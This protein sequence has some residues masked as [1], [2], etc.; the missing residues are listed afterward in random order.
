MT[1][2]SESS[3]K[4][5][6]LQ[7]GMLFDSLSNPQSGVNIEQMLCN[8][9]ENLQASAFVQAWQQVVERHPILRTSFCWSGLGAP[10]QR[11][12][13]HVELPSVE[14][15]WRN[16]SEGDRK[17]QLQDY[18]LSDRQRGFDLTQAP[19]MR[20][21]L[22]RM[23]D[24]EYALIWTFHHIL[25][26][27]ASIAILLQEVF[28]IYEASR[29]GQS[30]ELNPPHPYEDYIEWLQQQDLSKAEAFWKRS[31]SGF[32][33]PTPLVV[34]RSTSGG[35]IGHGEVAIR[36]SQT[37]T[38]TLKSL[39]QDR[40]LA[41][42]TLL[43]GAW[44]LLLSH[45]SDSEDV[46]FGA[47]RDCGRS[48]LQGGESRVGLFINTLPIRVIVPPELP[49][50]TWL[51]QLQAQRMSLQECDRTP[52]TKAQEW[53]DIPHGTPLFES[54][55]VF[56]SDAI[57]SALQALGGNW[58]NRE[59]QLL[60]QTSFPLT[61][62]GYAGSE[63]LLKIAYDR[64][65]FDSDT[66]NRM[67]GHLMTLLEGIAANPHQQLAQLPLL[68]V[69]E[70]QQLWQWNETQA[71]YPQEKCV[72][73]LFETQVER[74][75]DAIAALLPATVPTVTSQAQQQ[76]L[77][78]RELN[79]RANQLAHHLQQLGVGS[80]VLVAIC[81][82]RSLDV[83]I[84]V[85]GILKA[86][87]AYVPVD[88]AYPSERIAFMLA[89]TQAPVI[90]TQ[91]HLVESLPE[92]QARVVCLDA[93]WETISCNSTASPTSSVRP[94][95]LTYTIYTSGS[96]GRPKGVALQHRSLVNLI[97]WQLQNSTLKSEA[98]TLQFASLSFDV[99]F[100]EMF[101]TW[102]AG[103]TLVFIS[104]E[105]RRDALSL[106][107][108]I[109]NE[110]IQRLFLPF[111]AL[112]H[113]AEAADTYE[114]V[115]KAL[116]EVVTAGEQLQVNRYI[117]SFFEQLEDCS[118]HNQ[119][120][121]SE[122]HVVTAYT[123]TGS[124]SQWSALPPI[125]R[126]IANTQIYLLDRHLQPVPVGVP[127]EL[128][129]GGVGVARGYLNR[130]EL[131]QEKF[132]PNPFNKLKE[133]D[134]LYKSGD[135]ARYLP[136]G[137]IE[138]IGRI[139]NQ[140]KIRG[141]RIELGEIETALG[142][143]PA[144]KQAV[145]LVRE[146]EP[147]DKRLVA[148]IVANPEQELVTTE[149]RCYLL[150]MLPDYMIPAIFMTVEAMP[151]TPSGKIDRRALPAPDS[152]RHQSS[153]SYVAPQSEL[154]YCLASIWS[155][156]L[157]LDKVGIHDNFFELGGN[158]LLTLQIAAQ[159]RQK[160][161]IDLPIVKLFQHPTIAQLANYLSQ[162]GGTRPSNDKFQNRVERQK[163]AFERR[164][165]S[166]GDDKALDGVAIIGMV[167]RF[168][169]AATV[170]ELWQNLCNGV[171]STTF[172]TDEEL[173]SSIDIN[174]RT[175]PNYV[176]AR[177]TI[178]DADRFDAAFFGINPRE[179][180]VMD[181]Q[182]RVFLEMAWTALE[183]A[184]YEPDSY[185]GAVGVYAGMGNNTYYPNN[186]H[187]R[188][189]VIS[190]VGEFQVM[191][192][193]EKDY[194]AT[195][196]SY[197]LNLKGPSV[198]VHTACSTSL[199]A[200][201]QAFHSLM[202]N[203]CDL[204]L[205]GGISITVPQNSG[206]SYQEGGMFSSDGRC[207]P[208]DAKAQGTL[209][210]NGVGVVVL[211]RLNDALQDG[212]RVYAVIRGV[213][214]N[215]DGSGKM[216]FAAPSVDGQAEAIAMAHADA[217]VHPDTIS[218]VEAHGT[219]TPLG[220]PIEIAAL[221]QAF[222]TQ[223]QAK[224]F[225]AIGSLKSNFGH[226]VAAAG[227]TGLIKTALALK[228][229]QL[230]PTL[231][232]EQPNPAI[233]FANS[234]FYVNAKLSEWKTSHTPRRAG[235]SSFGVGGTNAHVVLEEAPI[236]EP[237]SPSR[238][239]Q[240][241]LLSAKT[242]SA[243]DAATT[244]LRVHL[245]ERPDINLADVAYTLQ[246]GRKQ[247]N[248]RRFAVCTD[249][250]EATQVLE[251]LPP[252]QVATR[253]ADSRNPAVIFM[254]PGQG[255]QY[256]NMGLNLYEREPV[257][258]EAVDRCADILQPLLDRDL[259]KVLYPGDDE[260]AAAESLRQTFVTQ[261][262][263]FTIEYALAMLWRSWGVH[264]QGAIGHSI[265]EFVAA[266]LAGVFSLENAL[267]LVATRGRLMQEL[268]G[269][270]MLSV[271]LPAAEVERRLSPELTIAAVNAPELCVVS[272]PTDAIATLQ[273]QLERESV[274]CKHLHTSHA[275]HSPMV[276]SIIEPFAEQVRKVQLSPPSIPFVSTVTATWI[277]SEQATDPMYWARHLRATVRFADGVQELWQEPN[278]VLLEVGPRTTTATLA[279]K[280]AKDLKK[281]V[282]ISSLNDTAANE[283]ECSA[284]LNAVGQLWLCGVAIDWHS[285]YK[286][287]NRYRVPLPTYPFERKRFWV[288][289]IDHKTG[290]QTQEENSPS[291]IS[292]PQSPVPNSQVP[293]SI[294]QLP[295][296]TKQE[297]RQD[298]LI[299]L[300]KNV[301]EETSGEELSS[302]DEA[303]TFLEMGLDSLSLTQ[304]AL[305]LQK[306]FNV[307]ITFRQLLEAFPT[308]GTLA[309]FLDRELPP[310]V[311]SAPAA[312]Q[313]VVPEPV[314]EAAPA[315]AALAVPT[316]IV[317]EKNVAATPVVTYSTTP[318]PSAPIPNPIQSGATEYLIAQQL[319]IM[320]RQLDLLG[321]GVSASMP[322]ASVPP[323]VTTNSQSFP[324]HL[325]A[326]SQTH[327]EAIANSAL[328]KP[329]A[330][331]S[332]DSSSEPKK[333]FGAAARI[334]TSEGQELTPQ[335]K[336][337]LE[338][339]IDR[340]AT[341]T[342][343][344]K[345]FTQSHRHHLADPRAVSGF[346]RTWKELIYPIVV[347]RSSGSKIW[348]VDGNEYVDLTNGFGS[349]FFGYSAPFIT[350]A[351]AAQMQRGFE[352]G[353]QTPLAGE[354]AQ[355]MCEL[356]QLDRVAFCNTGSEAVLGAMRLARTVTGRNTIAIFSGAYHGIFDEVIVRGTKKLR[357]LP[358]APGIPPSAVEN[359]LVV[360]YDS[361]ESLE[362]LK[363][364]A[365]DL[366]AILVEPV[367]S[368]R[369]EL[370]PR[371]FLHELRRITE[372]SGSAFIMDEVIT[373]F[374]IHPGG[375]QAHF[376]VQADIATY[377][378]VVGGGM[379]IGVIAGKPAFMDA[380]DGGFWQYGDTSFPEVGVTY[381]AGTF[382]RHPLVLA[383]AKAALEYLKRG[384]SQLQRSLNEKTDKFVAELN[385]YF[386]QVQVPFK[387][388]N[389]GSLFKV[390]YSHD[391]PYGELLFYWL[392][393]KGVHI[394]DHRPCF[395]TLA[396]SDAD[397][398]F[399]MEAFKQGIAQLQEAGFLPQPSGRITETQTLNANGSKNGSKSST[400]SLNNPAFPNAKLGRDPNGKP[401]WY[402]PDPERPGKYLQVG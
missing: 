156:L 136:D 225:C 346:N 350:E 343:K 200:V 25:L 102:C 169:G 268:P 378:K 339:L 12:H 285:F 369:P 111:I 92:H 333:V 63:L 168:P 205:A 258:R 29:S 79:Q 212:D 273:Q 197:K 222:H 38:Q 66:V 107:Q 34:A 288:E 264:P 209:F 87:G 342:R 302:V 356:T 304:I 233:D 120:G 367:Q 130:P 202:S 44:G 351:I 18:L 362:I 299:P 375:A 220:D 293:I 324:Q 59:F 76:Q 269:G 257:F 210:G 62:Y 82:E 89:D 284:L 11:V 316:P 21:A 384:G 36:L 387:I 386:Q 186:I 78:Y 19:V 26:D 199:V 16:L 50:L 193:N 240:L 184:G 248:Y 70:Q 303:T 106:L 309:E 218:Y 30:L 398:A 121:P 279:R 56:E 224:Q 376:G 83:A 53:S 39:A 290:R 349:N 60:E 123:L 148:Y 161:A 55:L 271:R 116:R 126:P 42:D 388:N 380:L 401:A 270:S 320:S 305:T 46:L 191:V 101:S 235:V 217:N 152:Q 390:T 3:Y 163:A 48:I 151:K 182:Q 52:L 33:A 132:I 180:E 214:L 32:D 372:R 137:N 145:V 340:Y 326:P 263:I 45:Y 394:W 164:Q 104:E 115:P 374:R 103:G 325:S 310:E 67:L 328:A 8:L 252:Q 109:D 291:L 128:Y 158:S 334:D 170:D 118:L 207:R 254:F 313:D 377:G 245:T 5:S 172:F 69:A 28:A 9:H 189:D 175:A 308:L 364:R 347:E 243:L 188:Q 135:L 341:R 43:Y 159:V 353:P 241:L 100:Q 266:C 144:V 352:I 400:T 179:A 17:T 14:Q 75:P 190:Q 261:P 223:T 366:A 216:S 272:G 382:I 177:G 94:D 150:D 157:K 57:S 88:P 260:V 280:Q 323:A 13:Q 97:A 283:A 93:D 203:Q 72:H 247:F 300:L 359:L 397:L 85:L 256:V 73:Q 204:A 242:Q 108:F 95:N 389:F 178:E 90:L 27:A 117:A 77:T 322:V 298:R 24:A 396:H 167:G 146:D 134:R 171:E 40:K 147:G 265:G 185:N 337:H 329:I 154:E 219:A 228:Y 143:H 110:T 246:T 84:A 231:H 173:D 174:L 238:P 250:S 294:P 278:R 213:G 338:T 274:L 226:L 133:S 71:D 47:T 119:Y 345:E 113:I 251:S 176:R 129:I 160:L 149:L 1:S 112:Q 96:T 332:A 330:Q 281:Q 289:P 267:M 286:A 37:A 363:A 49:V 327:E 311:L 195:R 395:L 155:K 383:A 162:E 122:T 237:S 125:G 211:K 393:E 68:A 379:P 215:N 371:E 131:T 98:R 249:L 127:G 373:G 153:Q 4:L 51:E 259:R 275:F 140:V 307:K 335:Q 91:T 301:F 208:F 65:R 236:V 392:R 64:Q 196:V 181:P 15:D 297:S 10:L 262:A 312:P 348:D 381:F 315:T 232:F 230:P 80:D 114:L 321:S 81:M 365:G 124:P 20:L 360:D 165:Q 139:D 138:Y 358:A 295:M 23:T 99:S 183:N 54:L 276:D 166:T 391:L 287:E 192:A 336:K 399:V 227:V 141:F 61:V 319:Q 355:L 306:E 234:P 201:C 194:L 318:L 35:K 255:S 239:R 317:P 74:T 206:Y 368:R 187:P 370:Q 277:T 198:S 142:T 2:S 357:S 244:N 41:L 296:S 86:G 331:T 282:A 229:Q 105:T 58:V 402:V 354:V 292:T 221:T 314:A 31:L 344:S 7:Q 6:P 385:A 361:P 253:Y 22:F